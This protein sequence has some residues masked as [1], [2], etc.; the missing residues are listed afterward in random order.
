[1]QRSELISPARVPPYRGNKNGRRRYRRPFV[2]ASAEITRAEMEEGSASGENAGQLTD[3]L[4]ML[5]V[6][7]L[8]EITRDL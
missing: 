5:F 4:L 6:L 8:G 2:S 3:R 1:M 7:D